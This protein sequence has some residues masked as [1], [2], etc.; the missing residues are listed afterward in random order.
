MKSE[1]NSTVSNER[2]YDNTS[3]LQILHGDSLEALTGDASGKPVESHQ[4]KRTRGN[5]V[6]SRI[7]RATRSTQDTAL[8]DSSGVDNTRSDGGQTSDLPSER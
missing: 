4:R 3:S 2:Q 1:L 8:R 5:G 6:A 7:S